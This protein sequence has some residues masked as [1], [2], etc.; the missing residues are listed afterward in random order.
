MEPFPLPVRRLSGCFLGLSLCIKK[1]LQ[2]IAAAGIKK[3][4]LLKGTATIARK[5]LKYAEKP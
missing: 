1:P 4:A 3:A 2:R 5:I